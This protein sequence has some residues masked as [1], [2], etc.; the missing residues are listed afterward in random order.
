MRLLKS[1]D[2]GGFNFVVVER[3]QQPPPYAILSHTW[4]PDSTEVTYADINRG[5]GRHKEGYRKLTFCQER[6]RTDG[7]D[8]FWSD[9][10]CID[11][12]NHAEL[13]YSITSM[14][15]WYSMATKCYVFLSDVSTRKHDINGTPVAWTEAF[16][17]ARWHTRGWTLQELIAPSSVE[18]FSRDGDRLGDKGSLAN[19]LSGVTS[20]S[21]QAL[22]VRNLDTVPVEE[23]IK[24]AAHRKTKEPEDMAYCMSGLLHVSLIPHYG[25]GIE[26]AVHRLEAEIALNLQ[27]KVVGVG[28]VL[29]NARADNAPVSTMS[30]S[31]FRAAL[32][33]EER[34]ERLIDPLKHA[35]SNSRRENIG[36]AQTGTCYWILD[37]PDY[38]RWNDMQQAQTHHGV[39]WISGNPGT[40]KS[41]IMKFVH[42]QCEKHRSNDEIVLS[43][44]FNARGD[45]NEK[46]T[47]GI[48]STLLYQL[49]QAAPDLQDVIDATRFPADVGGE[50]LSWTID[51]LCDAFS[52]TVM[53]LGNRRL[54]MFIDAL[55]ECNEPQVRD[56]LQ[57]MED[58]ASDAMD[59]AVFVQICF[60]SRHYPTLT[61]EYGVQMTLEAETGHQADLEKYVRARLKTRKSK[62]A[63]RL[64]EKV[65]VK[66]NGVFMW[67]V[68]VV[69][70]LNVEIAAGRMHDL[71]TALRKLPQ[72]LSELFRQ[73]IT[74]D[75]QHLTDMLLCFQWILFAMRPLTIH[76]FYY[77]MMAGTHPTSDKLVNRDPD[78][79]EDDMKR[80]VTSSSKGLAEL[81]RSKPTVQFIHESVRDFLLKDSGLRNMWP[82]L[83]DSVPA[84]SHAQL[85]QCCLTYMTIHRTD[86]SDALKELSPASSASKKL[87]RKEI[88]VAHPFLDYASHYVLQHADKSES[89][90]EFLQAF[91]REHWIEITNLLAPFDTRRHTLQ[92]SMLYIL[93]ENNCP[94]LIRQM[95]LE[96]QIGPRG[97][98]HNY[99]LFAALANGHKDAVLALLQPEVELNLDAAMLSKCPT[100]RDKTPL[101]WALEEE[102][103]DLARALL[104]AHDF[105]VVRELSESSGSG[106][107]V[108]HLAAQKGNI[109]VV[110]HI[111]NNRPEIV[112][113]GRD[114]CDPDT[115]ALSLATEAGNESLVRLLL[116]HIVPTK[117]A[118]NQQKHALLR[119]AACGQDSCMILLLEAGFSVN[120][121]EFTTDSHP[122]STIRAAVEG[123]HVS[124]VTLLLARGAH[125]PPETVVDLIPLAASKGHTD[126]VSLLLDR[127]PTPRHVEALKQAL[128]GAAAKGHCDTIR[129]LL[130]HGADVNGTWSGDTALHRA[131]TN[132][133]VACINILLEHGADV[134]ARDDREQTPIFRATSPSTI[135][136][137]VEAGAAVEARDAEGQT[138]LMR[139][140]GVFVF[141]EQY[142]ESFECLL[143][144]GAKVSSADNNGDTALHFAVRSA[145]DV[146]I[147]QL[148][149]TSADIEAR[150]N[151]GWTPLLV[152]TKTEFLI[153]GLRV[154]KTLLV[155]GADPTVE[156]LDGQT[157]LSSEIGR[158][159]FK[160][161]TAAGRPVHR[162]ITN[163]PEHS[164]SA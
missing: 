58:L 93:A 61:L 67:V 55:D 121:D 45:E 3:G 28:S 37:H 57:K 119:A 155:A 59:A 98:R 106:D 17:A 156:S 108:L 91:P 163:G 49:I 33:P 104:S 38:T 94:S 147:R 11:K 130:Q 152:A 114:R 131:V 53:R 71:E 31:T 92:A 133:H 85:R 40:G 15:R 117:C 20:I 110:E 52:R 62:A 47:N 138:P 101:F 74:R 134:E 30:A 82:Q 12:D 123:G 70:L 90:V 79:T 88:L 51:I 43:F 135:L 112:E 102:H 111:L 16:V 68:L 66:A 86:I 13:S 150:N 56:M 65:L 161:W 116:K 22:S 1:N 29:L 126:M 18:F 164:N 35:S 60:A 72:D 41:T 159:A 162:L 34:R 87:R 118:T 89:S 27:R 23:R 99:A 78:V 141:S 42:E 120:A 10:C 142:E 7:L 63:E 46:T 50:K 81:T 113:C 129:L 5:N 103:H 84:A 24:W 95:Y 109:E 128:C 83:G 140:A 6:A 8:V 48:W 151:I 19:L 69:P 148:L 97:E 125:F 136:I 54:R 80:F 157:L 64:R 36:K 39:L 146:V 139:S 76:E 2:K 9:T 158:Q 124:T 32:S 144:H 75:N 100:R 154:V 14:F 145:N 105:D 160:E 21:P 143:K 25:E 122:A 44:F 77:A 153:S 26:R 137:L 107:T 73:I 96:P 4:G 115:T 149:R 127:C 132:D